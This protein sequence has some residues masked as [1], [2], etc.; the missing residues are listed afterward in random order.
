LPE[1]LSSASPPSNSLFHGSGIG[2][3]SSEAVDMPIVHLVRISLFPITVAAFVLCLSLWDRDAPSGSYIISAAFCFI[4]SVL[5]FGEV[6][7]YRASARFPVWLAF[8]RILGRWLIMVAA[9]SALA[10]I[11]EYYTYFHPLSL[12]TW[13]TLTPFVLLGSQMLARSTLPRLILSTQSPRTAVI[14][15][16][17]PLSITLRTK[18][19]EDNFLNIRVA[20]FFDDRDIKRLPDGAQIQRLGPMHEL[21][22]YVK[23]NSV[24]VIYVC[25]PIVW[26][27]R[28]RQLLDD[29]NDTTASIYFVPDIFM[30]DLIQ[31]RI[32]T[33]TGIPTIAICETPFYG[34]R[35]IIK[36]AFDIVFSL[37]LLLTSWPILLAVAA[38]VKLTS[39]G[40]AIFKQ[41]RYGLDGKQIVVYKFR[42]MR[43]REDGDEVVQAK[44][45]DDRVTTF[46]R[47][48]RRTSLDELPQFVNVLQ[49]H[50]SVVG[51][52]PHAVSHNEMYRKVISG[53]M[54]RHKVK[55]GITGWAQVNGCR[56]ETETLEKMRARVKY[57]LEYLRNW[58]LSLDFLIVLR[59][60]GV[61]FSDRNAY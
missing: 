5:L 50:M 28:I 54:I 7:F 6:S 26:H 32:D 47:F 42:T 43:V 19:N 16:A 52:R 30:L 18:I 33:I 17:T 11:T 1:T 2:Q 57:D 49:G 9:V 58:S 13:L 15:G 22:N 3:G 48:L 24:A 21:P 20:G 60:A 37:V 44:P 35:G 39:P 41:T 45:H 14:V 61:I 55:P 31:A 10:Y 56:G 59:S 25:L 38:G 4:L 34:A 29:L 36:R 12:V 46:G 27:A 53:Y 23:Q 51:P 40:P 8:Y